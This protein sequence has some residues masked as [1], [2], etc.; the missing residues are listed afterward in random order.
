LFPP[1]LD[2][3]ILDSDAWVRVEQGEHPEALAASNRS[4][5][6]PGPPLDDSPWRFEVV[7][8]VDGVDV[9]VGEAIGLVIPHDRGA[10]GAGVKVAI[11][12][13]QWEGID[14]VDLDV[15]RVSTHDCWLHPSCLPPLDSARPR[16]DVERGFHGTSCAEAVRAVA[17]EADL[18]L[19]RV[20][21][22]TMFDA[23]VDWAIREGVDVISMS[24]SFFNLN[25]F[26]RTGP[27]SRAVRRL[28]EHGILLVTSA[29]NYAR[30]HWSGLYTDGDGDGRLDFD[31]SNGL[32]IYLRPGSARVHVTW[33]QFAS[34]GTTD[35]DIVLRDARGWIV[36]RGRDV[37]RVR[38]PDER[39]YRCS[40]VEQI[41]N[42]P[43]EGWYTLEVHHRRGSRVD[44]RVDIVAPSGV[45]DGSDPRGTIQ[46]PGL[47]SS[48]LTVGS[49]DAGAFRFAPPQPYSSVGP[50]G[51]AVDKPEIYGPDAYATVTYGTRGFSGTSA[52]TPIVAGMVAVLMSEDPGLS[53]RGAADRLVA[54]A[55]PD[56]T[57]RSTHPP[58]RRARFVEFLDRGGCGG[59][60]G[61]LVTLLVIGLGGSRTRPRSL[62]VLRGCFEGRN[63]SRG[64]RRHR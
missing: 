47:H 54:T 7:P 18:H 36:G 34:C 5:V 33:D 38:D 9:R 45:I 24:M 52:A 8:V 59:G 43:E 62:R 20:N 40:P 46:E 21:S 4:S 16:F 2:A 63:R 22:T 49:V 39:S 44:I 48:V 3:G 10:L 19:V 50:L 1:P 35:L 17:P 13:L 12:D 23:A 6:L 14:L 55:W 11:F 61:W 30:G 58:V 27:V 32:P 37:Q 60:P 51:L 53:P 56:P 25:F 31:G 15:G 42:V 41:R 28:E 26:D 29:G 64:A 57:L